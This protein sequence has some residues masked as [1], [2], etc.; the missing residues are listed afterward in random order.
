MGLAG[1]FLLSACSGTSK[2]TPVSV[3]ASPSS[4]LQASPVLPTS[5]WRATSTR[6]PARPTRTA[7]PT[8][9]PT[10]TETLNLVDA[11][12]E[13]NLLLENLVADLENTEIILETEIP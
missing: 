13:I 9:T 11:A 5:T 6:T 7:R 4:T 1:L 2:E 8:L 3:V 10:V 12:A